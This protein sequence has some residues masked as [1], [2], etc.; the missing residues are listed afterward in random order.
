VELEDREREGREEVWMTPA[1][2]VP[3]AKLTSPADNEADNDTA[4]DATCEPASRRRGAI[5]EQAIFDAVLTQMNAVGFSGL[6]M[7]GVANCAHTGKAAIYRRWPCKEDLVVD[8]LNHALPSFD[9]PPDTGNVRDDIA[10]VFRHMLTIINGHAGCAMLALISEL[11]RDHEFIKTVQERVL[12][13]RKAMMLEILERAAAR[14]EI[15]PD[16]VN[17][18]VGEAGPALIVHRMFMY[19]PPVDEAYAQAVLDD[20]VMP[21]LRPIRATT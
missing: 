15:R 4:P 8:A 9:A 2:P 17:P 18:L 19:G 1:Q 16:A 7:E 21:L 12:A 20:V 3:Q 14:G 11:D 6:T 13:P 5:L 10:E